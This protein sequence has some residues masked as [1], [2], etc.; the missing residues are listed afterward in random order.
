MKEKTSIAGKGQMII[1]LY[2]SDYWIWTI[3]IF[4][5]SKK[6][7]EDVGSI[8]FRFNMVLLCKGLDWKINITEILV[9]P[10]YAYNKDD[11]YD[12]YLDNKR[13][14]WRYKDD[15]C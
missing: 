11:I 5:K 8:I 12:V 2:K 10:K 14:K 3:F 4:V 15:P 1:P 7:Q 9:L 6:I 13:V